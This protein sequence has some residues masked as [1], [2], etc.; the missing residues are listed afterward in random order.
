MAK[1]RASVMI[2]VDPPVEREAEWNEWYTK[3]LLD[4]L[5]IAGFLC[6]R[7]FI[8]IDAKPKY[9]ALFDLADASVISSEGYLK[10]RDW[11]IAQPPDSFEIMTSK[12]PNF[13]RGLYE[14]VYPEG[15]DYQPPR[16]QVVLIVGHDV[17]SNRAAEFSVWYNTEYAPAVLR[18]PGVLSARRFTAFKG[19][20]S[21]TQV[22]P[23]EAGYLSV[24]D[25]ES[26]KVWPSPEF[27]K[28]REPGWYTERFRGMYRLIFPKL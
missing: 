16:S 13:S 9:L 12:L 25:L 26:E 20:L 21:R 4:R 19:E 6:A 22:W 24:Y 10:L 28:V 5:A 3:H 18:A 1:K 15:A 23:V 7:R 2:R 27:M 8:A 17:P 14:Q 11:E